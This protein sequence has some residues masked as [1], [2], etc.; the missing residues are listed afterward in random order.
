MFN[1]LTFLTSTLTV[2]LLVCYCLYLS[3]A[4]LRNPLFYCVLDH[5]HIRQISPDV[6][7]HRPSASYNISNEVWMTKA[8]QRLLLSFLASNQSMLEWGSGGSTLHFSRFVRM[9]YSIEHNNEWYAEVSRRLAQ[10][11]GLYGHVRYFWARVEPGRYGWPGGLSPGNYLQ[12]KRYVAA[13]R[14]F[15]PLVQHFD[16]VLVDGRARIACALFALRY[17]EGNS[18]LFLHDYFQRAET[19]N[20]NRVLEHYS[21]VA[22]VDELLVLRPK[23]AS[24]GLFLNNTEL[25]S[26][27]F[28]WNS[29]M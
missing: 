10:N 17:L 3:F 15:H 5:S 28:D 11:P 13:P 7:D 19:R 29:F 2:V 4:F 21:V 8:E 18:L 27:Y 12:F 6:P 23:P 9:Y 25:Q 26:R 14:R 22:A 1:S 24:A 16:R 20:Y